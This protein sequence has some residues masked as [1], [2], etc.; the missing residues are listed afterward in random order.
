MCWEMIKFVVA[1]PPKTFGNLAKIAKL[2]LLCSG[3]KGVSCNKGGQT[4]EMTKQKINIILLLLTFLG[5]TS[6]CFGQIKKINPPFV[7][8]DF[9][10]DK[11]VAYECKKNILGLIVM[12]DKLYS[13]IINKEKKLSLA[14]IDTLHAFLWET[15]K[16][17]K[18]VSK[19]SWYPYIGFVYYLKDSMVANFSIAKGSTDF[20]IYFR[21]LS[22]PNNWPNSHVEFTETKRKRLTKLCADLGFTNY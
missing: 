3:Y 11:V 6:A 22:N 18:K 12:N 19:E 1:N 16:C 13:K 20:L 4:S 5:L 14:Q 7:F 9:K 17:D 10:Y 2:P 8:K 15:K 21:V